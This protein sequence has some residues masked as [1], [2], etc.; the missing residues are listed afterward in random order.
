MPGWEISQRLP[1]GV[2]TRY[3]PGPELG[4]AKTGAA[5]WNWRGASV[6]HGH[7]APDMV[8]AWLNIL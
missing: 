1:I 5:E 4:R 7:T 6:F 2:A 3:S 8:S